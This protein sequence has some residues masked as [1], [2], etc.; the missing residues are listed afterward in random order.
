MASRWIV[1]LAALILPITVGPAEAGLFQ[2]S[3]VPAKEDACG[4]GFHCQPGIKPGTGFCIRDWQRQRCTPGKDSC[5]PGFH[6]QP[7]FVSGGF[8]VRDKK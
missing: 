3:C 8:C 4:P 1:I 7:G 5:G 2:K 6:C